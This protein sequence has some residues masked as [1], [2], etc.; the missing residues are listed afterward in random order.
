VKKFIIETAA[1]TLQGFLEALVGYLWSLAS[2]ILK[3]HPGVLAAI[4]G[5]AE[6][7][8]AVYGSLAAKYSTML[9]LGEANN[10][11]DLLRSKI[12][13][14]GV[15]LGVLGGLYVIALT[16]LVSNPLDPFLY[17]LVSRGLILL[18]LVPLT[19]YL[20]Y[21][22]FLK[23]LDVDL[24]VVSV[25]TVIADLLSAIAIFLSFSTLAVPFIIVMIVITFYAALKVG[26][27]ESL[28][29]KKE[30]TT[31]TLLASTISTVAGMS[32]VG[33][34]A[35]NVPLLL[36][37]AP[38]VMALNGSASMN[39]ASWLGTALALGEIEPSRPFNRKVVLTGLRVALEVIIATVLS[40]APL[41]LGAYGIEVIEVAV[42]ATLILRAIMPLIAIVL[43]SR[44]Y[45]RGWDPDLITIPILS[46]LSDLI[47]ANVLLLSYYLLR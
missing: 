41:A 7:R 13:Y 9:Y 16:S 18:V 2:P 3:E 32:L 6:D 25:V 33:G 4:P 35:Q 39:F 23:G 5:L 26:I 43:A 8:G 38:L 11:V 45:L 37:T 19:A 47:S 28:K 14:T 17:F 10:A 40:V 44:S 24:T 34:G 36:S 22:A 21:F 15:I 30:Y 29:V 27:R 42:T 12:T 31:S 1:L 46:S 20:C